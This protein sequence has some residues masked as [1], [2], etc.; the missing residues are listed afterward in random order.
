RVWRQALARLRVDAVW[1]VDITRLLGGRAVGW[2]RL[3]GGVATRLVDEFLLF[4]FAQHDTLPLWVA[5]DVGDGSTVTLRALALRLCRSRLFLLCHAA[6]VFG[7]G[8]RRV[9]MGVIHGRA[10]DTVWDA[11]A[12][13]PHASTVEHDTLF[14]RWRNH[15]W[16]CDVGVVGLDGARAALE[17][18]WVWIGVEQ[19]ANARTCARAALRLALNAAK[20]LK[21]TSAQVAAEFWMVEQ[22][23]LVHL[24]HGLVLDRLVW[25][26]ANRHGGY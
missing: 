6:Q 4:V 2:T 7:R 16:S 19:R 17:R 18:L 10:A 12:V 9:G 20:V 11:S 8:E 23:L 24:P 15:F 5:W 1:T 21:A 26:V 14:G 3:D 25:R 13:W 22:D